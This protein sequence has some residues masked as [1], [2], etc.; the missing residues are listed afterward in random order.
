M[1]S[2]FAYCSRCEPEQQSHPKLKAERVIVSRT[3]GSFPKLPMTCGA[4]HDTHTNTICVACKRLSRTPGLPCAIRVTRPR[5]SSGPRIH[6]DISHPAPARVIC[7]IPPRSSSADSCVGSVGLRP[8]LLS[9][10]DGKDRCLKL[11]PCG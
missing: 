1:T 11:V 6:A 8:D 7:S 3:A 4:A 9:K 5:A 2:I 10:T